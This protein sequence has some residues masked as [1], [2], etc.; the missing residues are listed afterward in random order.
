[1]TSSVRAASLRRAIAAFGLRD[2]FCHVELR[3]VDGAGPR[4]LEINPRI[5]AGCVTDSIETFTNLDVDAV[6]ALL[7]L[8]VG[9]HEGQAQPRGKT[10]PNSRFAAAHQADH[11]DRFVAQSRFDR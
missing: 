9:V 5:G 1:M 7:D 6:R 10:A 8:L 3:W 2:T 4:V 11:D